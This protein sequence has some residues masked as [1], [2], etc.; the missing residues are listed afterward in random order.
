MSNDDTESTSTMSLHPNTL[1]VQ[2]ISTFIN[3]NQF[4][5]ALSYLMSLTQQEIDGN[6]W[7]LC[8]YLFRLYE[9]PLDKLSNQYELFSQ[10]ALAYVAEHGNPREMLIIMLEQSDKFI[11]DETFLF[12][13]KLY[14]IIIKRLPIRPNLITSIDDIFS[15]L[16]CHLTTI[17]L[18]KINND[19]TG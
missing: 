13:I 18:P 4:D 15:V 12:H 7:D 2:V 5:K 11:S 9:K 3:D 8:T 17:E 14:L 16:Q 6:T 19:F 10:D 1:F